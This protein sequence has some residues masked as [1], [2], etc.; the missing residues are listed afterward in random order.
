MPPQ[1]RGSAVSRLRKLASAGQVERDP[2][3]LGSLGITAAALEQ[4]VQL[5]IEEGGAV[6]FGR[7]SDGGALCLTIYVDDT[8]SKQYL[9]DQADWVALMS[10]LVD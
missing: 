1:K 10:A 8:K 5:V 3:T 2:V 6:M 9:T 4:L 7:T